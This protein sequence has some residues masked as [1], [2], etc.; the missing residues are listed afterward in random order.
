MLGPQLESIL[1]LYLLRWVS[2]YTMHME[3]PDELP[4]EQK[5]EV[6]ARHLDSGGLR[7]GLG[8]RIYQMLQRQFQW[9]AGIKNHGF[10]KM[11]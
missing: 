2:Q 5:S 4:E 3:S 6:R 10:I 7:R 1:K 11:S 9:Q 8:A